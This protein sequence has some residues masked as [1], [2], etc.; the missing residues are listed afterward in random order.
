MST[1][2]TF[3]GEDRRITDRR[4][5][6]SVRQLTDHHAHSHHLY[7]TNNGFWDG[8]RRL[9]IGSHRGNRENLF[10]LEL[11]SGE[12]TQLT[13]FSPEQRASI[14]GAFLNPLRDEAY[15]HIG[16]KMVAL[17]LRTFAQ[18]D[19]YEAPEGF[20]LGNC[21]CSA[22]G[23]TLCTVLQ[24]DLSKRINMDLGHGYV[25]FAE[26]SAARP[27][28]RIITI[29]LDT[30]VHR[31]AYEERF[32]LG[33]I[34]TSPTLPDVLTFCHEGPWKAIEQRM[35]TLRISTG[36]AIALREQVPGET[37]GH[38]YWFADGQRVGYH[39]TREGVHRFGWTQWDGSVGE[40]YD[41]PFG[42]MHFHS[43]DETLIVGDGGPG[44]PHLLLWRLLEGRYE[45]P[46]ILLTHR[47]SFHVQILHVHPRM[48]RSPDG[49]VR[50]VYTAD[51][52]GYGN[53]FLVTVPEL[54]SLPSA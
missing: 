11:E 24:E 37:I 26:Y 34:N 46:K 52:N 36:E 8:G 27:E 5:G 45:G 51:H 15:F 21:S 29:D 7:F 44:D 32:W 50:I 23:K 16:G 3:A 31:V 2:K 12:M 53:V 20:R 19:L 10:S 25:G 17:N 35:W 48:D 33:H 1:G 22:D 14:Q 42:S 4:T 18:R 13:D 39:G 28:C 54:D 41:F 40:E 49:Q 6:V 9:V 38:E 47:G 43:L 30:G